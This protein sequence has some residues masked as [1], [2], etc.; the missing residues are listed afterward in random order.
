MSSD[1]SPRQI[2]AQLAEAIPGEEQ[3]NVIVIGSLAAAYHFFRGDPERAVRTKDVDCLL[4]PRVAAVRTGERMTRVLL[5]SDWRFR[6]DDGFGEPQA[7]PDPRDKLSAIRLEPPGDRAW[8]LELLTV[9]ESEDDHGKSWVPIQVA[10]RGYFG[11]CSFEFLSLVAVDP[12]PTDSRLRYARPELM[13]LANL[14]AHPAVGEEYMSADYGDRKIKR[15]AKDL[16]RVLSIAWLSSVDEMEGWASSWR[17]A[18]EQC[19]PRR[20]QELSVR[21][22]RGLAALMADAHDFEQAHHTCVYG[23]LAGRGVTPEQLRATAE[24]VIEF[25]LKRTGRPIGQAT[26]T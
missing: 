20:W 7:A 13:A 21:A 3:D 16:G 19:F 11:L 6:T 23:L 25:A 26:P 22:G 10:E 2:F 12:L 9:P 14:L 17:T 15:S 8:F 1:L 18:L 5:E 4:T 24:R